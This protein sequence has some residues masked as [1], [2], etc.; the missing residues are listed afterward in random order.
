MTRPAG[1][2]SH[3]EAASDAGAEAD[4]QA[5][6]RPNDAAAERWLLAHRHGTDA[7][8]ALRFYDARPPVAPPDVVGRWHGSGWHTG[9][10]WDGLLEALGWYGKDVVDPEHV[11]PTL[12]ADRRGAPV[13]VDPV[14]APVTLI[15]RAPQALRRSALPRVFRTVVPLLRSP[16]PAGRI[17]MV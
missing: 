7:R 10:R 6:V 17:R 9:H 12:F 8:T 3:A 11:L 15:R 4:A 14:L 13:P 5:D 2:A 1:A 16:R